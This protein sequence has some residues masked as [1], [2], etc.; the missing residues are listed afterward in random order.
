MFLSNSKACNRV[1]QNVTI[2]AGQKLVCSLNAQSCKV[3]LTA[4]TQYPRSEIANNPA[5]IF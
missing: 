5:G 4:D 2:V 3:F 1:I